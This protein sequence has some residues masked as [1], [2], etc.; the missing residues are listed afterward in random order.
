MG[1]C[2]SAPT[3]PTAAL[4]V[5][6]TPAP[7]FLSSLTWRRAT[8]AF[9]TEGAAPDVTPIL[10]AIHMAPTSFGLSPFKVFVVS[11]A[12]TKTALQGVA[13][14][15]AQVGQA[16]HLLV[17]CAEKECAPS[18][19]RYIAAN[20]LDEYNAGYAGMIRG[21]MA[22]KASASEAWCAK[23]TYIALGFALAAA[24][25][26]RIPTCPMEGFDS[27]AVAKIVRPLHSPAA[28]G[29]TPS[30]EG[31][32]H[33]TYTPPSLSPPYNPLTPPFFFT[34]QVG[35]PETHSVQCILAVGRQ[36]ADEKASTGGYPQFRFPMSD[37]I[38]QQ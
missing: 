19:E 12:E 20:K 26:L 38:V 2:F 13:Y 18:G 6:S 23:Q 22:S 36:H 34:P 3:A 15:Q 1:S 8:K 21:S 14:G 7:S 25:E 31:L 33:T 10:K 32:S 9:A 24:A 37:I 35:V 11:A 17:F 29:T 5:R 4:E 16:S 27:S 30:A 28:H